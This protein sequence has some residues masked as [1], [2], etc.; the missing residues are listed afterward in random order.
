[1]EITPTHILHWRHYY[2]IS[3]SLTFQTEELGGRSEFP[4]KYDRE[5]EVV[6]YEK[7]REKATFPILLI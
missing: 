6:K 4:F 2:H 1:M 5:R 7:G 3:S